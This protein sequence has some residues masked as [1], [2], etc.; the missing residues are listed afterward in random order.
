MKP[1]FY[2]IKRKIFFFVLRLFNKSNLLPIDDSFGFSIGTPID[3]FY[4]ESFLIE[5]VE[6]IK[7]TVC[8]I[9][10]LNYSKKFAQPGAI[11]ELFDINSKNKHATIIGDLQN[12]DTIPESIV[13]C[14]ILTQTLN[15]IEDTDLVIQSIYKILRPGGVCLLT[16]SG[17]S[18]ISSY[19]MTRWGDYWRFT[20][21]SLKVV[22]NK[23]FNN[24]NIHIK[25][26]GNLFAAKSF[27]DGECIENLDNDDLM[28][29]D[30]RYQITICAKIIK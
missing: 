5:N 29:R 10:E 14:F 25:T 13:D 21:Y 2:I 3:R 15:F 16:V 23:C 30:D 27:L 7:G 6:I 18:Q 24:N 11:F 20:D 9:S 4:I 19:D 28:I 22:L 26:Y 17:I 12:P 8:E 1:Y